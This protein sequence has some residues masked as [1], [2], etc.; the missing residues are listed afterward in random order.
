MQTKIL[1]N[2]INFTLALCLYP[3]SMVYVLPQRYVCIRSLWC[4]SYL[5]VMLVS[6]LY[7]ICL[8]LALCLYPFSMVYVL[9]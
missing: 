2:N 9:P 5:S 3:F 1:L 7:G 4:M 6:V 8:T